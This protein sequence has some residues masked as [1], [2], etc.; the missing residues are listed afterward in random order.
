[1][2]WNDFIVSYLIGSG[3][4]GEVFL[5]E[6]KDFKGEGTNQRYAIKRMKKADVY[7]KRLTESI[8]LEKK[9]LEE[10]VCSFIT[11]LYFAFRDEYYLYIVMEWAEGG[12]TYTFIKPG[13]PRVKM[14]KNIG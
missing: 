12:D 5:G 2:R 10:S 3:G 8:R 1:M 4:F 14:F 9:I 6:L 7:K 13:S 11:K